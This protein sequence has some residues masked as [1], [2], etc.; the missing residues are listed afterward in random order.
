MRITGDESPRTSPSYWLDEAVASHERL[1][2]LKLAYETEAA[3]RRQCV[4]MA[5]AEGA[6]QQ[7]VADR[8]G[9][10][11]AHIATNLLK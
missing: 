11:R 5:I 3:R 6:T 1:H 4:R 10:A 9:I 7:E 8:L 2:A